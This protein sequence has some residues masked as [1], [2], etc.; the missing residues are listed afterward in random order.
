MFNIHFCQWLDLNRGPLALEVTVLPT[1]P[2]P[3]PQERLF[4]QAQD[5]IKWWP[6]ANFCNFLTKLFLL[7]F[8]SRVCVS[9]VVKLAR[10]EPQKTK[11]TE[12][13][14]Q[15]AKKHSLGNIVVDFDAFSQKVLRSLL[16]EWKWQ[17]PQS[18]F[19]ANKY[20]YGLSNSSWNKMSTASNQPTMAKHI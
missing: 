3:L 12:R 14:K 19:K 7:K 13:S 1:E 15:E 11:V 18:G 4:Y 17:Q 8:L 16:A 2:Q 6:F 9:I 10:I 5:R 20:L